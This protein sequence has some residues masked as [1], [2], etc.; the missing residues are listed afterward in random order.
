MPV[1]CPPRRL[2]PGSRRGPEGLRRPWVRTLVGLA[3][4]VAVT[5]CGTSAGPSSPGDGSTGG[6][7]GPAAAYPITITR[8]GGLVG[9]EDHLVVAADGTV[10]GTT[11]AGSL[12]C[13]LDEAVATGLATPLSAV[14]TSGTGP[15]TGPDSLVITVSAGGETVHL[16]G[17]GT[18]P[19]S[20]AVTQ[21]LADVILPAD[22]RSLCR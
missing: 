15:T 13:R 17:A 8:T 14:P 18:D 11:R 7:T 4:T 1:T 16:G 19:L 5:A 6:A 22:Q 9:F 3:A 10:T 2:A 21:L 12:S 20:R